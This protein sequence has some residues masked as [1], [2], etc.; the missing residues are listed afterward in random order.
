MAYIRGT[1]I[2]VPIPGQI[3][4]G[5]IYGQ[6]YLEDLYPVAYIR[7]LKSGDLYPGL[8]FLSIVSL[9]KANVDKVPSKRLYVP[10][11]EKKTVVISIRGPALLKGRSSGAI[12]R[13]QEAI[14][15][16]KWYHAWVKLVPK[17]FGG[18]Q[19]SHG[20]LNMG[21]LST[22]AFLWTSNRWLL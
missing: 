17:S 18:S 6:L 5:L 4:G 11:L 7:G 20:R 14:N 3:S 12:L 13:L 21:V 15:S 10:K 22:M 19:K 9:I 2:W 8:I 16:P 1:Y